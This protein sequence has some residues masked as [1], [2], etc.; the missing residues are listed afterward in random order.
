M[1]NWFKTTCRAVTVLVVL[2]KLLPFEFNDYELQRSANT[3]ATYT[4][5]T[6][7]FFALEAELFSQEHKIKAVWS[8]LV[9]V[10]LFISF[11]IVGLFFYVGRCVDGPDEVAFTKPAE[12]GAVVLRCSNC[13]ATTDYSDNYY[14]VRP[15]LGIINYVRSVDLANLKDEGWKKL[16]N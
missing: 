15:I 13:G 4:L 9:S 16:N 11:S 6:A 5:L 14:Y 7:L 8:V 3:G 12:P 2:L 10:P 1:S